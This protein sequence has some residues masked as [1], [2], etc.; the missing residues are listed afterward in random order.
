MKVLL[1]KIDR[2]TEENLTRRM[3]LEQDLNLKDEVRICS[4]CH[5]YKQKC[6]LYMNVISVGLRHRPDLLCDPQQFQWY[7]HSWRHRQE[8]VNVTFLLCK[9]SKILIVINT[10]VSWNVARYMD[11][12][13]LLAWPFYF[14]IKIK[15]WI[16]SPQDILFSYKNLFKSTCTL[17]WVFFYFFAFSTKSSGSLFIF[18]KRCAQYS[19]SMLFKF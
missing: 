12:L 7:Q 5:I 13:H 17:G 14:V 3:R 19:T 11:F 6:R 8:Q 1:E 9:F 10:V 4:G 16:W 18:I 15:I 2:Q